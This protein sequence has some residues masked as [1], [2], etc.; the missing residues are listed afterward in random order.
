[1][2]TCFNRLIIVNDWQTPYHRD[3]CNPVWVYDLLATFSV[4]YDCQFSCP[5]IGRTFVYDPGCAMVGCTR[6]LE[7][8]ISEASGG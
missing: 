8:G 5:T 2:G 6:L 3:S 1:W 4:Y 7:Y